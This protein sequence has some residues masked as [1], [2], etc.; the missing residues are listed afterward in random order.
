MTILNK[1]K[2]VL[3]LFEH[4]SRCIIAYLIL[5]IFDILICLTLHESFKDL[6]ED[7][8]GKLEQLWNNKPI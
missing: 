8:N 7:S 4:K 1:A 5:L 2:K 6:R 3:K